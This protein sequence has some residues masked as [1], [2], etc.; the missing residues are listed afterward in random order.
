MYL[1]IK[2]VVLVLL[3]LVSCKSDDEVATRV[4][5]PPMA[6]AKSNVTSGTIPLIVNFFGEDSTDDDSVVSYSWNFDDGTISNEINPSHTFESP[7]TYQVILAIKDK[8]G[9]ENKDNISIVVNDVMNNTPVAIAS[10]D[11]IEGEAPLQVIF[12]GSN[13]SDDMGISTYLWKF[14]DSEVSVSDTSYTF[15]TAGIYDVMLTVIDTEG[16]KDIDTLTI[17]VVPENKERIACDV[18]GKKANETGLKIWCWEE[19]DVPTGEIGGGDIFSNDQLALSIE[20]NPN[21]VIKE[22]NR[23]KFVLNPI[24]PSPADWCSN[25]FNIRSE[26]R[27]MPWEINSP[28]G[29]EEWFGWSYGFGENY[30]IDKENPWAFFQVHDGTIGI[31]PLISFWIMN[32]NG[33]GGG[34]AGEIHVV[35]TTSGT[36]NYATTGIIPEAGKKY[37]IVV[38]VIWGDE[39]KGLL[40]VWIDGSVVY[41]KKIRTIRTNNPVGGNAKFGIY[42]WPWANDANVQKSLEQGIESLETYMGPLRAITRRPNDSDYGKNSYAQVQP[43]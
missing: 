12:T 2:I 36:N 29:T 1:R 40:E 42:K 8:E 6:K 11:R 39:S 22:E 16:L 7:G 25:D 28:A 10:S 27:T 24:S 9:L 37:N 15:E 20:C 17:T 43:R 30:S 19:I 3:L 33:P 32:E 38:H 31:S 4:N 14:P 26:I 41:N 23:L 35:N 5:M 34:N 13:S 21:Q 18:G